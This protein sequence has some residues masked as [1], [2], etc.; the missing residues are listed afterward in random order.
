MYN[1]LRKMAFAKLAFRLQLCDNEKY[2]LRRIIREEPI[3]SSYSLK[4]SLLFHTIQNEVRRA[5]RLTMR[6]H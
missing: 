2:K 5:S 3:R 6:K 4:Q 1:M